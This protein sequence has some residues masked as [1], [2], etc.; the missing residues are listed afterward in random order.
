MK[1]IA[2]GVWQFRF[3]WPNAF[4]AYFIEGEGEGIVVDASTRWSWPLMR[5]QLRGRRVTG[6]VLTHAHPDHQ[7]CAARICARFGVPLACH[8]EDVASA[9]GRAPLVRQSAVW[10]AVGNLVWAGRRGPVGR[11]LR[12]GD[13]IAGFRVIHLPGHTAGHLALFREGDRLAIAGDVL[14]TNDYL[15]GLF[16]L[17]REPPRTFSLDPAQNRASIR[18]L[19]GLGPRVI[20]TGHGPV[21][22]DMGKLERFMARLPGESAIAL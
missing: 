4:N 14:N 18:K 1:L 2:D 8:E 12:E 9:E 5:G 22:R 3:L 11:I 10:E 20:C 13:R 15:T 7:G 21:M 16:T 6:M 17:V 19:W